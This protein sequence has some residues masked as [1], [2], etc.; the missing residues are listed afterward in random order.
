MQNEYKEKYG[1]D[2]SIA[3]NKIAKELGMNDRIMELINA[4][5]FLGAP[6]NS[7]DNDFGKKIIEYC[8]ERVDPFGVVSLEQRF[9]DLRKRYTS[10]GEDTP[11]RTA[12]ENAVRKI[13]KQIFAKCKIQPED[14]NDE[15]IKPYL[16]KLKEFEI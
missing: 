6:A 13:E 15:S 16:E 8:D 1:N 7:L 10:F 4:I 14:I 11:E 12:F 3:H 2:E 5:S 9:M